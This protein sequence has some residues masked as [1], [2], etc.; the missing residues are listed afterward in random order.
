MYNAD[1][2]DQDEQF[3]NIIDGF[4]FGYI[5]MTILGETGNQK[6]LVKSACKNRIAEKGL[7]GLTIVR[8]NPGFYIGVF[9]I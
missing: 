9:V 8:I 4:N 3:K 5:K 7:K 6:F 2:A 1:I